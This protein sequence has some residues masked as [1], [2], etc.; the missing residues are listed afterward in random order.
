MVKLASARESRVYGPRI[1]KNRAEYIN[2]GLYLFATVVLLGGFVAQLSGEPKSGLVLLLIALVLIATINFHDALAHLASYDYRF[3]LM[4]Y[5]VQL[6]LVEFF[7]PL[8]QAIGSI[9]LFLGILF[10][11]L[12][13]EK[14]YRYMKMEKHGMNMLIAGPVLWV[15]GSIHNSCQVYERADGHVQI[16]QQ[17]VHIPF[18]IGSILLTVASILNAREHALAGQLFHGLQLLGR[19]WIWVSIFGSL[20]LVIGGLMNVVKVFHMQSS[21]DGGR[22]RLEKLR[23]GAQE[24]LFQERDGQV[25]LILEE[26][27]DRQSHRRRRRQTSP[28]DNGQ[29][30]IIFPPSPV[31]VPTPY[32]DILLA[33]I[34]LCF[35]YYT[36]ASVSSQPQFR[37]TQPPSKVLHLRNLPW[38]CTEEELIE[39]GKPFGKVVNTKCNVGANRNQAFIEFADLNQAIAMISYYASSSEPAQVRGKT[40]YLQY[41]NR[42]EI[43]NNKTAADVAGNVLLVTIEGPDARLVSIDVLHLVFSAFGFVHKITTFEKTAGF[44]ALVQFSD[45]ETATSAKNALDGRSIPRYLL[46]ENVG[47]CTLRITYSGHTDLSVKFQSHRSRDYTNPYLPVAPSAIDGSGQLTVGLDGKK[48]EPE[49]NVL[50]A[51]IENMQYAV[52]LE[53]LHMVFSSFGP[54]QKIAMFDKN[55]GVQALVQYPEIQTAVAAKEALEGHCIY[56]GGFCKL[57]LSYSRH[58]DLSIKVNNDRSRDYTLPNVS[59][60]TMVNSQPSILGQQPSNVSM[61]TTNP[62]QYSGAQYAPTEQVGMPQ[63]LAAWGVAAAPPAPQSMP[64]P[65]PMPMSMPMPMPMSNHSYMPPRYGN[66]PPHPGTMHMP[67]QSGLSQTMVYRPD[68][69]Q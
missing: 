43:V 17:S 56:D 50:L 7:V 54:V 20:F 62:P 69:I 29:P 19:R 58:T 65:M 6:F 25:P 36:M 12:Q 53:V 24:R 44:Q 5:D 3:Y 27:E 61:V 68:H 11:F 31:P 35:A 46:T 57:H 49:S 23:G 10:L 45:A 38:E 15:V 48:L 16:L 64:M 63:P 47:P 1:S 14:G 60:V 30:K 40:V 21:S 59:T 9:L 67:S 4:E 52:T 34:L 39:L 41:S 18:L 66:M 28:R 51:S 22:I 2:A 13:E 8:V 37:Y 33:L 42:Q 32:K 26:E 55:G